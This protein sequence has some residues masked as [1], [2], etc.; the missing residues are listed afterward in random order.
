MSPYRQCSAL[1]RSWSRGICD[2]NLCKTVVTQICSVAFGTVLKLNT[3]TIKWLNTKAYAIKDPCIRFIGYYCR[4][5][6]PKT[7]DPEEEE[8][9][10]IIMTY[11]IYMEP[12]TL[13]LTLT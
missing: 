4:A 5:I 9:L 8:Y 3:K 6:S 7:S 13:T 10:Y 2:T 11:D 1:S 12:G